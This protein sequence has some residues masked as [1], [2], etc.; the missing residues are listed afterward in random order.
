M[1][2]E[3]KNWN[4]LGIMVLM[5]I[6]IVTLIFFNLKT[7]ERHEGL[8][9]A[10]R[11]SQ[12]T[13]RSYETKNGELAYYNSVIEIEKRDLKLFNDSLAQEIKNMK[14]KKPEVVVRT[15]TI[16]RI[17]T[18]VH[19][20]H[21]TLPCEDFIVDVFIDSL[22]YNIDITLTKDSLT[23]NDFYV[24]NETTMVVGKKRGGFFK[25]SE[26]VFAIKHTNPHI[27][28]EEIEPY[29]IKEKGRFAKDGIKLGIG[30][31]IGAILIKLFDKL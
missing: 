20:F 9:D 13:V 4:Q 28:Q 8:R 24:P 3:G 18:V 2:K 1:A 10:L 30:A 14:I 31:V 11:A 6:A 21:D 27:S 15:E 23:I 17:D 29:V 16:F 5:G 26:Y 7:C 12:D 22:W 19:E 25:K